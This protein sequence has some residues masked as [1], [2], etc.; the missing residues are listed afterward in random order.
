MAFTLRIRTTIS[1]RRWQPWTAGIAVGYMN[2]RTRQESK[3]LYNRGERKEAL[4]WAPAPPRCWY[5]WLSA[6]IGI[7]SKLFGHTGQFSRFHPHT[8]AVGE[9]FCASQLTVT[10]CLRF[11]QCAM[12]AV[13]KQQLKLCWLFSGFFHDQLWA[14]KRSVILTCVR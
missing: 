8:H 11:K 12:I 13:R 5:V 6:K 3:T 4:F 14:V 1:P 7:F 10:T 9:L 2:G